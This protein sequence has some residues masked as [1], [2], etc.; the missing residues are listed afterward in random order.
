MAKIATVGVEQWR[1][2]PHLDAGHPDCADLCLGQL[3]LTML[4]L[5]PEA[6]DFLFIRTTGGQHAGVEG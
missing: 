2:S 5:P 4:H 6:M 1:R 3:L